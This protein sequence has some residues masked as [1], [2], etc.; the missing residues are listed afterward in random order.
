MLYTDTFFLFLFIGVCG[1]T[2]LLRPWPALKEW[3][4][5][6]FS[7]LVIVSWGYFDLLLFLSVLCVNYFAVKALVSSP[8]P[9]KIHILRASI[10][11]DVLTLVLFKY[12]NFIGGNVSSVIGVI[13]PAF[14]LG[15]PLA[16]SFYIFHL[17]SYLIDVHAGRVKVASTREYLFYLSFF[18]HVI[19][20]PIVRAWQLVPQIGKNRHIKTDFTMGFHYL[21]VGFFL[22]VVVANNIAK[23]IDPVWT[24][25]GDS[26]SIA[27]HWMV[28][29]LY[30]CQIYG[31]FA[32]YSLMAL[33]M[34]R[35][36]GY[37][38][39]ANFRG[40]MRAVTLQE[41]WQRW[42]ITLSKWLRDYLY[43]SLGGNRVSNVRRGAN[44]LITMLLGGLWHGA[45]WCFILWGAMHGVGIAAEQYFH[46]RS[47]AGGRFS[48]LLFWILTQLW[49]T[50][51]WVFFRAPDLPKAL[52]FLSRM[53]PSM[54]GTFFPSHRSL[55]LLLLASIPILVHNFA[56]IFLG[57]IKRR[58]LGGILGVITGFLLVINIIFYSPKTVFIYFKF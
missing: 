18:P 36:L 54:A 23:G 38:L 37:R 35:L 17:I 46:L 24:S 5:I 52:H 2:R 16:I 53:I 32:G 27:D 48:W 6:V 12:A 1:L 3:F 15:I 39:P 51:A 49:V 26:F 20:G 56:P 42:H 41:F 29:F 57:T 25:D 43:F 10:I 50:M 8:D 9:R 21:V 31:D 4:L 45:G 44:V 58:H 13:I 11:F 40:P 22:K 7:W 30:Y 14:P 33:G 47:K 28:A 55:V 34:A 19:A